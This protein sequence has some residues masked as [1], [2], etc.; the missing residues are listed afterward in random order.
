MKVHYRKNVLDRINEAIDIAERDRR[1]ILAIDLNRKEWVGFTTDLN[2]NEM[3]TP[4]DYLV[5]MNA[6]KGDCTLHR[7]VL[8]KLEDES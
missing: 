6:T 7:G 2:I 1:D 8:V 5:M 3:I 4:N